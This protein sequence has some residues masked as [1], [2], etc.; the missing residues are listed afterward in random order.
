[1]INQR[2]KIN[3]NNKLFYLLYYD[4]IYRLKVNKFL[5]TIFLIKMNKNIISYSI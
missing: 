3:Y 5:K 4:I 1:M 2:N